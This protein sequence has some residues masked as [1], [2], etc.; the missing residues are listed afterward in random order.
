MAKYNTLLQLEGICLMVFTG[1]EGVM[2]GYFI[3]LY[4]ETFHSISIYLCTYYLLIILDYIAILA[5]FFS[6]FLCKNML[7]SFACVY[8]KSFLY[9]CL[10]ILCCILP[11]VRKRQ[12]VRRSLINNQY[13][14]LFCMKNDLW[15]SPTAMT[16]FGLLERQ[17]EI[18]N[19]C[20]GK[21]NSYLN[22]L[23][24]FFLNVSSLPLFLF[25]F[26]HTGSPCLLC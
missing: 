14:S 4:Y 17:E 23:G 6:L 2:N 22:C 13:V 21:I 1:A 19:I 24:F 10:Y 18:E 26:S 16:C 12:K 25:F 9:T 15:K 7:S 5:C 3:L 8:L 20:K 11:V